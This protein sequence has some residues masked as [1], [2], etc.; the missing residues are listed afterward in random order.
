M[1]DGERPALYLTDVRLPPKN[2]DVPRPGVSRLPPTAD[3]LTKKIETV[4][5]VG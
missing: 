1:S 4:L 5:R 3:F 2:Q